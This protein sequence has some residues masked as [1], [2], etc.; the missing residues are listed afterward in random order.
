M[1]PAFK[2][3]MTSLLVSTLFVVPLFVK[4][5]WAILVGIAIGLVLKVAPTEVDVPPLFFR[6]YVA[7]TVGV[8][9]LFG[10]VTVAYKDP[11]GLIYFDAA[12][13]LWS[14]LIVVSPIILALIWALVRS[15]SRE[16]ALL[17]P[18]FKL[19]LGSLLGAAVILSPLFFKGIWVSVF[20]VLFSLALVLSPMEVDV[21]PLMLQPYAVMSGLI[22]V[23]SA[24]F[25]TFAKG[26]VGSA[27]FISCNPLVLLLSILIAT[28][29]SILWILAYPFNKEEFEI[30]PPTKVD[31]VSLFVT[32]AFLSPLVFKGLWPLF[33]LLFL[34][35]VIDLLPKL[36]EGRI[37]I[38]QICIGP[39]VRPLLTAVLLVVAFSLL[40]LGVAKGPIV[41]GFVIGDNPFIL[42]FTVVA[43]LMLLTLWALL[44]LPSEAGLVVKSKLPIPE[45]K[46][47]IGPKVAALLFLSPLFL[48]GFWAPIVMSVLFFALCVLPAEFRTFKSEAKPTPIVSLLAIALLWMLL[49]GATGLIASQQ[50]LALLRL[51]LVLVLICM[52]TI[53][54][55]VTYRGVIIN[56]EVIKTPAITFEITPL[57]I[58]MVGLSAIFFKLIWFIPLFISLSMATFLLPST[59]TL[60]PLEMKPYTLTAILTI[61]VP[62]LLNGVKVALLGGLFILSLKLLALLELSKHTKGSKELFLKNELYALPYEGVQNPGLFLVHTNLG[63]L[64]PLGK[65]SRA[66][67][68]LSGALKQASLF[69]LSAAHLFYQRAWFDKK[70][71]GSRR[72]IRKVFEVPSRARRYLYL[73]IKWEVGHSLAWMGVPIK[74][75]PQ[76]KP[77]NTFGGLA[78][79]KVSRVLGKLLSMLGLGGVVLPIR[80]SLLRVFGLIK[81]L[82]NDRPSATQ[83]FVNNFQPEAP[84]YKVRG[85]TVGPIQKRRHLV[86]LASDM[87]VFASRGSSLLV[88]MFL[89]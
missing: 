74:Q 50:S 79:I 24:L 82:W 19:D 77:G 55:F 36:L 32:S 29:L 25:L 76:F 43:T 10:L 47:D 48:R 46:I 33:I 34:F 89:I 16:G 80:G 6:P 4:G 51:A 40:L 57:I 7:M 56:T 14:L 27:F 63:L 66:V 78:F 75:H 70:Y 53:M 64:F 49:N 26:P 11:K 84:T 52:L 72:R 31:L 59:L 2:L 23:L 69:S 18:A 60:P 87:E 35:M 9:L 58:F 38:P 88:F 65:W 3:D 12:N 68:T 8:T 42:L 22:G 39:W 41:S 37:V 20:I 81:D 67:G 1:V 15:F 21:P 61:S 86:N 44:L 5:P 45:L 83:S 17:I 13:P 62:L 30:T 85:F 71:R 73:N 54:L 28:T